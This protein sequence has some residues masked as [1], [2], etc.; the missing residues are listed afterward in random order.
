MNGGRS[1]YDQYSN[2]GKIF[3]G[4]GLSCMCSAWPVLLVLSSV[5]AVR[6][7]GPPASTRTVRL[8]ALL[9][10]CIHASLRGSEQIR[11]VQGRR[12][13]AGGALEV[14]RKIED[15]PRS[16]LTEA[17]LAAQHAIVGALREHWGDALTIV[18][19]EDE[20]DG[21][22]TRFDS[23]PN[24]EPLRIDLCPP[25]FDSASDVA[26]SDVCLFVDPLDGTREFVEGRRTPKNISL[27]HTHTQRQGPPMRQTRTS[28]PTCHTPFSHI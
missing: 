3:S 17:D 25:A 15:D 19:E 28:P 16:A 2:T 23:T 20:A 6:M 5:G 12:A 4:V 18:G 8:D 26:L 10:S 14:A 13:A 24:G 1:M 7:V 27:S 21:G 9:S 22:A 11:A